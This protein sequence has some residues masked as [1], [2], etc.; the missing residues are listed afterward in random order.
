MNQR[1]RKKIRFP[2]FCLVDFFPQFDF[3]WLHSLVHL[4]CSSWLFFFVRSNRFGFRSMLYS[5]K[6]GV[7]SINN[8]HTRLS[9]ISIYLHIAYGRLLTI[10]GV[11]PSQKRIPDRNGILFIFL[12]EKESAHRVR[13]SEI[14]ETIQWLCVKRDSRGYAR[15]ALFR[16]VRHHSHPHT[17][18]CTTTTCFD[19]FV[20]KCWLHLLLSC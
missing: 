10:F 11:A 6:F 8:D 18:Q 14:D 19:V 7:H 1:K 2:T 12:I 16:L 5:K 20:P 4:L 9:T 13:V 3:F 15:S 17:V